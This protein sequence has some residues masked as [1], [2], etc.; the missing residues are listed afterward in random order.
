MFRIKMQHYSCDVALVSGLRIRVEQARMGYDV[1][2]VVN[3]Q[4]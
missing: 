3:G 4:Y 1:L 2:F